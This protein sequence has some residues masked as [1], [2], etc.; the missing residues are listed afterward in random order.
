MGEKLGITRGSDLSAWYNI[1]RK[2]FAAYG[3]IS[4]LTHH[5]K[6]SPYLF[7]KNVYAT[8][9]WEP[10]RFAR[11]PK[12]V[13]QDDLAPQEAM[14]FVFRKLGFKKVEDWHRVSVKQLKSLRVNQYFAKHGG[15]PALLLKYL[16]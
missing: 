9:N 14:E 4:L 7:L 6:D 10:W 12:A 11:I 15:L 2:D 13:L 8:H 1:S 5:Y 3:G 16:P